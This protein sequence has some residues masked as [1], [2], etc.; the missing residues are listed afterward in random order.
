MMIDDVSNS[1]QREKLR[2]AGREP[3]RAVCLPPAPQ[4]PSVLGCRD[5][6]IE[7]IPISGS[8]KIMGESPLER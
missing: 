5:G 8:G 3:L 2:Q 7:W 6:R 4:V 1:H